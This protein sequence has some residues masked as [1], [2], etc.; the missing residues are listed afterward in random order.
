[1]SKK[2]D[3]KE[4]L[5]L[6]LSH[7]IKEARE[8]SEDFVGA[9]L[10]DKR[11]QKKHILAYVL[12]VSQTGEMDVETEIETWFRIYKWIEDKKDELLH[13][14]EVEKDVMLVLYPRFISL[15]EFESLPT[16]T[17]ERLEENRIIWY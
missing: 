12:F 17:K 5:Q 3:K 1:M 10:I 7:V 4:V 9:F 11:L 14:Y 6:Y 8:A 13:R 16:A 2:I 15:G